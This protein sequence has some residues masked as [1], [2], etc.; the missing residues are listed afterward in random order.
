MDFFVEFAASMPEAYRRAFGAE[1]RAEHA[2]VVARRGGRLAHAELCRPSG[3]GVV[4]LVADDRP[5]LLALVTDA[6]LVHGLSIRSAQAYC[7]ERADGTAEAVDVLELHPRGESLATVAGDFDA[8]ELYAF[9]QTLTELIADDISACSLPAQALVKAG[10]PTRVYFELEALG[11]GKYE[12]LVEA[13]DSE[14]LLHAIS[15]AIDAQGARIFACQ[16]ATQAG[17]AHDRFDLASAGGGPLSAVE[18]CDI[19]LAVFDALPR[20]SA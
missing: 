11:R 2:A 14:G 18:L 12:L 1:D 19:Q 13:A 15:T 8:T 20:R 7:R 4:C 3:T 6:L 17:R 9:V 16:I 10:T 5:G